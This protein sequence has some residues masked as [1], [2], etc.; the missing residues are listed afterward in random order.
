MNITVIVPTYRRPEELARCLE[1]LKNQTLLPYEILIIV[2]DTDVETWTFLENYNSDFLPIRLVKVNTPGQVAALNAGLDEA[3]S[4]I[5]AITD[6]DAAPHPHWLAKIK[7]HFLSDEKIG[8]V[9]GRD[10]VYSNGKLLE[11]EDKNVGKVQWFGR[12]IGNH[13]IGTGGCREVDILKGANMSYRRSAIG[14]KRFDTRL[15]GNG[16]QIHNDMA[17]SLCLRKEGWKLIYDP[18]VSVDHFLGNRFDEDSRSQFNSFAMSNI[19]HNETL[20]LLDFFSII[21]KIIY[22]IW[23]ILI[24][25][26]Q[27]IGILQ[28]F[29]LLPQEKRLACKK[30]QA[31]LTGRWTGLVSWFSS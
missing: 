5:I 12:T 25:S 29:R 2:R 6:D 11:G 1:A 21:K 13:H 28:F 3:K 18:M 22:M 4:E 31:S 16:S 20:I 15:K 27:G 8:G 10:W 19:V 24:G 23:A 17:F 7:E 26:K 14:N 30:F 9:G